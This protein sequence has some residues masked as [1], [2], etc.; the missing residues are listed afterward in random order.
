[1]I[2]GLDVVKSLILIF[3]LIK[4]FIAGYFLVYFAPNGLF[5]YF[6]SPLCALVASYSIYLSQNK[7]WRSEGWMQPTTQLMFATLSL[8]DILHKIN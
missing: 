2:K 4:C 6:G 7:P 8:K 3:N 1:M 5:S